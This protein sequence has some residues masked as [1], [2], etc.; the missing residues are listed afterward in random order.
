MKF[1]P[2]NIVLKNGKSVTIREASVND[3]QELINAAKHYLGESDYLLS[4]EDEFNPTI[5]EETAWIKS[6]DNE[7]S[8]LLVAEYEDRIIAT[9]SM[10]GKQLRKQKHTAEIAVAMLNE[11]QGIGLG[12]TLFNCA[13]IWAR[14]HSLLESIHLDVFSSN[15]QAQALYKKMGFEE[16]GRRKNYFK[17]DS[18]KYT[19][20]LMMSLKLK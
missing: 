16:D 11:W 1:E 3:A 17:T 2:L 12:S 18:G 10:H 4:Y 6:M 19:D 7:N 15:T 13:I 5:E 9:F 20:N 8:L 14:Q